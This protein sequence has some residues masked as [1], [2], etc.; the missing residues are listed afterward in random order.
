[1]GSVG[2]A[3][4]VHPPLRVIR[5][6]AVPAPIRF[7]RDARTAEGYVGPMF[8]RPPFIKIPECS[9]APRSPRS[10]P[11]FSPRLFSLMP[12]P[13][14]PANPWSVPF[15]L[16]S[17]QKPGG[18]PLSASYALRVKTAPLAARRSTISTHY[19]IIQ[20]NLP[21][22]LATARPFVVL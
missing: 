10:A 4:T 7:T 3:C 9:A 11:S 8:R 20:Q 1:V 21:L 5:V 22:A 17:I 16:T 2:K 6:S 13:C 19:C 14:H 15:P 18:F 12:H